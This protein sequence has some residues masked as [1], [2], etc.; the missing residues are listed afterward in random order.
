MGDRRVNSI[1]S[2]E[3]EDWAAD[4]LENGNALA[5]RQRAGDKPWKPV[6]P[7]TVRN[8]Q[9]DLQQ[10]YRWVEE[11]HPELVSNRAL[12]AIQLVTVAPAPD[13]WPSWEHAF[14]FL[15]CF[16]LPC[17]RRAALFAFGSGLR[18]Q[19]WVALDERHV[20]RLNW[21]LTIKQTW[22]GYGVGIVPLAKNERAFTPV[23]LS[24]LARQAVE[25]RP[26]RTADAPLL[27][28]EDGRRIDLKRFREGPWADAL[29]AYNALGLEPEIVHRTPRQTRHTFASLN[30]SA[31]GVET[32][33]LA[34]LLRN[35]EATMM[36]Y[37]A[38]VTPKLTER[39][40]A[41]VDAVTPDYRRASSSAAA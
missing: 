15:D 20:N 22:G 30:L 24:K 31:R 35:D 25:L 12:R 7:Q 38:A 23:H 11:R 5:D 19:E 27:A 33:E 18:P 6:A 29:S 8:Y 2:G 9:K 13:P 10:S 4:L 1:T 16:T 17:Y 3:I 32:R 40:A 41:A 21:V 14:A 36:R 28:D 37:Y 39:A 26:P 34:A